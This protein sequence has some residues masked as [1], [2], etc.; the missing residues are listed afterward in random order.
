MGNGVRG[1]KGKSRSLTAFLGSALFPFGD[2]LHLTYILRD[3]SLQ[4]LAEGWMPTSG[5]ELI[6]CRVGVRIRPSRH[7]FLTQA[8]RNA[9]YFAVIA[10]LAHGGESRDKRQMYNCKTALHISLMFTFP[11]RITWIICP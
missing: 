8:Q 10:L 6:S 1:A 3:A 7:R 11:R 2:P 4:V 9:R 5:L